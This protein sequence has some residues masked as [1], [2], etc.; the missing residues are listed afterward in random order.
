M[1]G[2]FIQMA[3]GH[4]NYCNKCSDLETFGWDENP[5]TPGYLP[6]VI[7]GVKRKA[8]GISFLHLSG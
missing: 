6:T 5:H 7:D 4:P 3:R 8:G 1:D 2:M